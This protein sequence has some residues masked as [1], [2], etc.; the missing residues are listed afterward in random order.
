MIYS[1]DHLYAPLF[2]IAL[3]LAVAVRGNASTFSAVQPTARYP[4]SIAIQQSPLG[5]RPLAQEPYKAWGLSKQDWQR[6]LQ[7]K[8]GPRGLWSPDLNPIAVLGIHSEEPGQRRRLASQYVAMQQKRFSS[9]LQ[10]QRAVN[11]ELQRFWKSDQ[12]RPQAGATA[13]Q[14]NKNSQLLLFANKDCGSR[15]DRL[16]SLATEK[17]R[18]GGQRLHIFLLDAGRDVK[19]RRWARSHRIDPAA[20]Q[21]R[22]ITLNHDRGQWAQL[23]PR[24]NGAAGLPRLLFSGSRGLVEI[25][26]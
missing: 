6:Y 4:E 21:S 7:I 17:I 26:P 25:K 20:V 14:Q 8:Q 15:C 12:Q 11:E 5:Q 16:L 1:I 22:R 3:L 19:L 13:L 10:F 18:Q 23:L 24:L 2:T 9:E